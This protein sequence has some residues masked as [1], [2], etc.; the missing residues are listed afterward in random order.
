MNKHRWKRVFS[1]TG[2]Y[3]LTHSGHG[4]G[5][6]KRRYKEVDRVAL[7][8]SLFSKQMQDFLCTVSTTSF[9][10]NLLFY[11][12]L[13]EILVFRRIFMYCAELT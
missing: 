6:S 2:K 4:Q 7:I 3:F 10:R 9:R 12:N 11:E 13:Q 1:H 5:M 8:T